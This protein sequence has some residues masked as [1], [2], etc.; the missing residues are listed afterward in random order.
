[1]KSTDI[2]LKLKNT[3]K[4][5]FKLQDIKTLTGVEKYEYLKIYI[6]RM[7]KKGLI[8]TIKKGLY[9]LADSPPSDFEIANN[10]YIPSYISLETALVYYGI[11][12]QVPYTITSVTLKKANMYK[13]NAKEYSYS[14]LSQSLFYPDLQKN[15]I[16]IASREKTIIDTIYLASFRGYDINFDEWDLSDID[17]VKLKTIAS[18]IEIKAFSNLFYSLFK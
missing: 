10:L 15:N 17:M 5:I 6:N 7:I 12:N 1:M 4:N 9:Y 11:I 2:Y 13:F 14:H 3:G 18:T 16:L 8:K